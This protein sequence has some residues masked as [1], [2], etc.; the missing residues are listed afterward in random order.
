[1]LYERGVWSLHYRQQE[2]W[3]IL[4]RKMKDASDLS[5]TIQDRTQKAQQGSGLS[6]IATLVSLPQLWGK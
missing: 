6:K 4:E 1:M 2:D 3:R 5:L